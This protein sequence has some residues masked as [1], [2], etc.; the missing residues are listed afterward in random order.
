MLCALN[1]TILS[2]KVWHSGIAQWWSLCFLCERSQVQSLIRYTFYLQTLVCCNCSICHLLYLQHLLPVAE[3]E[4]LITFFSLVNKRLCPEL[5]HCIND[6]GFCAHW[7]TDT[8][9]LLCK[10]KIACYFNIYISIVI[11]LMNKLQKIHQLIPIHVH[12]FRFSLS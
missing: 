6:Q 12:Y 2:T 3:A 8:I 1:T 4:L 9:S 10:S 5:K 7:V 11:A